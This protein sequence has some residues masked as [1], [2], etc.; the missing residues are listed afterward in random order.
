M[1]VLVYYVANGYRILINNR[2]IITRHVQVID[3]DT[4]IICLE[5]VDDQK[6][7]DIDKSKSINLDKKIYVNNANENETNPENSVNDSR[8]I[9]YDK[10]NDGNLND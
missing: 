4:Q 10:E 6:D 8:P 9:S 7:R 2:L 1:G 5:R 3:E